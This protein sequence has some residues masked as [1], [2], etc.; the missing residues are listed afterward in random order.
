MIAADSAVVGVI[1]DTG[2][3][4][5]PPEARFAAKESKSRRSAEARMI[6]IFEV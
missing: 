2:V 3:E 1:I 6:T 5:A 4:L